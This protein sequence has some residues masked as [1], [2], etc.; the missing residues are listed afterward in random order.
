MSIADIRLSRKIGA[1]FAILV[2]GAAAMGGVVYTK[3]QHM[4]QTR[5]D[6]HASNL[7]VQ[8]ALNARVYLSRQENALRGLLLTQTSSREEVVAGHYRSFMDNLDRIAELQAGDAEALKAVEAARASVREWRDQIAQPAIELARDPQTL[9]GA[10]ELIFSPAADT[11][12][13]PAEEAIEGLIRTNLAQSELYAQFQEQASRV[14]QITLFAGIG[15]LLAVAIALG[16]LL[17][18]GIALPVARLRDVML[19]LAG[20]DNAVNVPFTGRKDEIGQMAGSVLT[21]K[22]AANERVR[23]ADEARAARDAQERER[24]RIAALEAGSAEAL[25]LF[26]S[27]IEGGFERLAAGD[28]TVRLEKPVAPEYEAIRA[29]FN[30]SVRS[31]EDALGSVVGSIGTLRTG[32][33][34]INVAS[35][36][37]AQRTEQQAASLEETVA[38]LAEVTR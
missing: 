30:E 37:L 33:S 7:T 21:F 25:R 27:D 17:S 13:E 35:N 28:L 34:E 5:I 26:V 20:G 1:A 16:W 19:A 3:L 6:N 18:R 23:L 24:E 29:R 14:S 32:L 8:R 2:I 38:A 11:L 10:V 31:L 9:N 12:V 36:D 22:E 15:S 4:E